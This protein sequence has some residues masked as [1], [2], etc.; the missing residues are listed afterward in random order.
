VTLGE[1][2]EEFSAVPEGVNDGDTVAVT[3]AREQFNILGD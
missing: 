2:D 3:D 1:R